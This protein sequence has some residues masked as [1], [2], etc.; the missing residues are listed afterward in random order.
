MRWRPGVALVLGS[1]LAFPAE[2]APLAGTVHLQSGAVSALSGRGEDVEIRRGTR[3]LRVD[4]GDELRTSGHVEAV[5]IA[6]D[7]TQMPL[8]PGAVYTVDAA[9]VWQAVAGGRT[10]VLQFRVPAKAAPTQVPTEPTKAMA[11]ARAHGVIRYRDARES[12]VGLLDLDQD[13]H[14]NS[15]LG[16]AREGSILLAANQGGRALYLG[17]GGLRVHE[18]S[19][20]LESGTLAVLAGGPTS[21]VLAP[22]FSVAGGPGAIYAVTVKDGVSTVR[23]ASGKVVVGPLPGGRGNRLELAP[24]QAASATQEGRIQAAPG[25]GTAKNAGEAIRAALSSSDPAAAARAVSA[26]LEGSPVP[27]S[28]DLPPRLAPTEAS[29]PRPAA[30][31]QAPAPAPEWSTRDRRGPP[32]P[33]SAWKASAA[34][35]PAFR[36]GEPEPTSPHHP[37]WTTGF[38]LET[39]PLSSR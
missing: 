29:S 37:I 19:L 31:A 21:V 8:D 33:V 22:S 14:P 12:K 2:A 28:E 17:P 23:A 24:G 13:L 38:A 36:P 39:P 32:V 25:Q 20:S 18:K 3:S 30:P 16:V 15:W 7:E 1:L 11:R 6:H 27:V 34:P 4:V 10:R 26:A 9:G 35:H 5:F